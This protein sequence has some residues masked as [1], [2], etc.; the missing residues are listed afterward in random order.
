MH[1]F[2]F[3]I[4]NTLMFFTYTCHRCYR[5]FII[6]VYMPLFESIP[7]TKENYLGVFTQQQLYD[8]GWSSEYKH[9]VY[10]PRDAM[11]A[12]TRNFIRVK[13]LDED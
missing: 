6:L 10:G 13:I 8:P 2:I 3:Q 4:H 9:E 1:C 12:D 5:N 11:T 7:D